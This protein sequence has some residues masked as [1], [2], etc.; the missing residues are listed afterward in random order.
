MKNMVPAGYLAKRVAKRPEWFHAPQVED[1]YSLSG[2]E[3]EDFTDYIEHW[4]HNGYWLFDS[5]SVIRDLAKEHSIDLQGTTL[6]YYEIHEFEFDGETWSPFAPDPGMTTNVT[7]PMNKK[8]MGFDVVTF[9]AKNRAECSPLSCNSMAAELPA[10]AHCLFETFEEA[11]AN[12]DR[13]VFADCEP[14][15]Y[16]IFGVF[17]VDWA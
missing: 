2:C 3:S 14:G 13:G 1:I 5:E 16:R 10:N 6:F 9:W 15:P 12:L 17:Y 11:K 7:A 4:K 8:L